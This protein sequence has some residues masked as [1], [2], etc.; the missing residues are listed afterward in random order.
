MKSPDDEHGLGLGSGSSDNIR[1]LPLGHGGHGAG[2]SA[3]NDDE[4]SSNLIRYFNMNTAKLFAIVFMLLFVAYHGYLNSF[5]GR[6][7]CNRLLEEGHILGN[8]EWQPSGCMMHTYDTYDVETCLKYVKYYN[9]RNH[10]VFIGDSRIRQIFEQFVYQ[11]D[12]SLLKNDG[13]STLSSTA[14]Q[15]SSTSTTTNATTIPKPDPAHAIA[16]PTLT[17]SN[18]QLDLVIDFIWKPMID[19]SLYNLIENYTQP[20]SP[21]PSFVV[22]GMASAYINN[23]ATKE[24]FEAFKGNLSNLIDLVKSSNYDAKYSIPNKAFQYD[25]GSANLPI[26]WMIQDPIDESKY[27][28]NQT[29]NDIITNKKID[30]YNREAINLLYYSPVAIWSSSRLVSQGYSKD[31][32]N[33]YNIGRF[34]RET[35]SQMLYNLYCNNRMKFNDASCCSQPEPMSLIQ[36]IIFS[37]FIFC[38]VIAS[39]LF[40][41]RYVFKKS[42]QFRFNISG[43]EISLTKCKNAA[44]SNN[45]VTLFSVMARLALI[46]FYFFACDRANFFMKENKHFTPL[47]FF[48]PFIYIF[49]LG[50]FFHESSPL[51]RPMSRTQ[52]DECKG[53]MQLVILIYQIS[54]A[55]NNTPLFLIVR[56]LTSAYL[57]LSGYGHFMYYWNTPNYNITRFFEVLFRLNFLAIILCFTMNRMYQFYTFVPLVTFSYICCYVLMVVY[58]RLSARSAKEN[59]YHYFYMMIKL[60][61]LFGFIAML[62]VSE[63]VFEKIFMARPWKFLFV[64]YDVLLNDWRKRWSLDCFSFAF[65]MSFGLIVCILRRLGILDDVSESDLLDSSEFVSESTYDRKRGSQFSFRFRFFL[66]VTSSAGFL[67]YLAFAYLCESRESCNNVTPY[68]TVIPIVSFFILRNTIS[69]IRNKFSL[70]FKWFG[71]ITLEMFV[72]SFHILLAADSNGLLVLLP[73]QPV[74]NMLLTTFIF[75]CISHELNVITTVLSTYVVPNNWRL[76]LRNFCSFLI[77][78]MPIAIKYGYI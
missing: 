51:V 46:M 12:P 41:Y 37:V 35:D 57:F 65:G 71:K 67:G 26:Y 68:I 4:W 11:L 5:Y 69:C 31:S 42:A 1:L 60:G 21:K 8:T 34:A 59:G 3:T 49:V 45:F 76:C 25:Q 64:S 20:N 48:V 29:T 50:V 54:A 32:N 53:F 18:K 22:M 38:L 63:T 36:Q 58:P 77:L 70:L 27:V 52:T 23:N 66:T 73:G 16:Q 7:S 55:H 74:L 24:S 17:Y 2:T 13:P 14:N 78:M 10:F 40:I 56:M 72:C 75:L 9:R 47:M 62:N 30:M 19:E 39:S 28:Y 6:N 33:G 44:S 61:I 43:S 15:P